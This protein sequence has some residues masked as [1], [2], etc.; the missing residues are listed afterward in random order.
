MVQHGF[1]SVPRPLPRPRRPR[2]MPL[3]ARPLVE[4]LRLTPRPVC[5]PTPTYPV[6]VVEVEVPRG[7]VPLPLP[8]TAGFGGPASAFL[9]SSSAFL[10]AASRRACSSAARRSTACFL[11]LSSSSMSA[12]SCVAPCHCG[13]RMRRW[14]CSVWERMRVHVWSSVE[15]FWT[16]LETV[17]PCQSIE[18]YRVVATHT[19][20]LSLAFCRLS[21]TPSMT[22]LT[23]RTLSSSRRSAASLAS[24]VV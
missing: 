6:E 1:H 8:L 2:P 11:W 9:R 15:A 21:T 17:C 12:M 7:R 5:P 18:L 20:M 14:L 16:V 10:A 4:S 24:S 19:P 23:L 3:L 22:L 13:F